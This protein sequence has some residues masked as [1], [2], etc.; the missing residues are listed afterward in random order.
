MVGIEAF[1][2]GDNLK[3]QFRK[4]NLL[5]GTRISIHKGARNYLN[6]KK[7]FLATTQVLKIACTSWL[8]IAVETAAF[9]V[10]PVSTWM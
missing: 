4:N 3:L 6:L 8:P 5:T 10:S 2:I 7:R 1:R 9:I